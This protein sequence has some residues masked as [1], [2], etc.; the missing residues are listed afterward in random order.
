MTTLPNPELLFVDADG[1]PEAINDN[2]IAI[3]LITRNEVE[4][5]TVGDVVHRLMTISD[6][7]RATKH[8]AGRVVLQVDGYND[9]PRELMEIQEIREFFADIHKQ[10]R[11]WA[12]FLDVTY[13]DSFNVMLSLLL[14]PKRQVLGNRAIGTEYD[15]GE[16]K[17]FL[18]EQFRGVYQLHQLHN[19]ADK[20]VEK[21][22]LDLVSRMTGPSRHASELYA[23]IKAQ[24]QVDF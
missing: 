4:R 10:W 7:P 11:Y 19:L 20:D 17:D 2:S 8:L 13:T 5:G 1:L 21:R 23:Q 16:L 6:D 12:H 15:T 18:A 14:T 9:D 3:V 24:A 22:M